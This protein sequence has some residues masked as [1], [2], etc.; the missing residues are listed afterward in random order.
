[1]K[2]IFGRSRELQVE[3]SEYLD[4][5]NKAALI[6]KRDLNRY[7]KRNYS[8]FREDLDE[9]DEVEND[10]DEYQKDIKH[11]LYKYMLIPEARGDVLAILESIDTVVDL[12]KKVLTQLSVE[13]PEIYDF[14]REDYLELTENSASAVDMLVK[15]VRAYFEEISLVNDYVNKVHFYEHEA[16]KN[17]EKILRKIF[18]SQ[19]LDDLAEKIHIRDYTERVASLSDKAETISER[20]SVAAIKRQI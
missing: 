6:F 11:K 17:E 8:T 12:S 15:S 3:I 16:D 7:I 1:M 2:K 9:I 20:V 14:I 10:A 18:R 13:K 4:T 5:V 19:E